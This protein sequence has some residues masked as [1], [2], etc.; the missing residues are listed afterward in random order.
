MGN[1]LQDRQDWAHR[2]NDLAAG[3]KG[4]S[5]QEAER[6]ADLLLQDTAVDQKNTS[7]VATTKQITLTSSAPCG[8]DGHAHY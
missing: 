1:N 7:A 8:L 6:R 3:W 2:S 4:I 5:K